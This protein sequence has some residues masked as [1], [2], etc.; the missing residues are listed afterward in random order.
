V[1]V[2]RPLKLQWANSGLLPQIQ[3][4]FASELARW[5]GTPYRDQQP[6][7]GP[8][9]GVSCL[10]F[11]CAVLDGLYGRPCETIIGLPPDIGL[12]DPEAA[13]RAMRFMLTRYP[14][15]RVEGTGIEPGDVLVVGHGRTCAPGHVMLVGSRKNA[16]WHSTE[17]IG[18]HYTGLSLAQNTA[19]H[20]TYRCSD[21]NQWLHNSPTQ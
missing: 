2:H 20:S 3:A 9:G 18:V 17:E 16:L 4:A 13:K 19:H 1:I 12:H 7:P 5:E 15:Q 11:V 10:G 6:V 21:R 8:D 14:L